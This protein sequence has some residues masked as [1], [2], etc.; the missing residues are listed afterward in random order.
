MKVILLFPLLFLIS[1]SA[2]SAPVLI[3][4]SIEGDVSAYSPLT[5]N[6]CITG[7]EICRFL[8]K[9]NTN[10]D[11][12][13]RIT[14]TID[15]Q[16]PEPFWVTEGIIGVNSYG[17]TFKNPKETISL[18][19][20][21]SVDYKKYPPGLFTLV[22]IGTL[23]GLDAWAGFSIS[24]IDPPAGVPIPASLF[25]FAPGLLGFMALRRKPRSS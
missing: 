16:Y 21:A 2:N 18:F 14:A 12:D 24:R 20:Y 22:F 1:F 17:V 6:G 10:E 9:P 23:S 4:Y 15:F 3:D 7:V 25:L 8:V 11:V 5:P 19:D 13:V